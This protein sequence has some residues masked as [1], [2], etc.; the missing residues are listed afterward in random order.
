MRRNINAGY[1]EHSIERPG[2]GRPGL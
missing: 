2:S 1:L